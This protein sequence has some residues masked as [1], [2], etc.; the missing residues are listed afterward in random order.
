MRSGPVATPW[1]REFWL[2]AALD[3]STGGGRGSRKT[4]VAKCYRKGP[5]IMRLSNFFLLSSCLLAMSCGSSP[6]VT[7]PPPD[8]ST[9]GSETGTAEAGPGTDVRINPDVAAPLDAP[10]GADARTDTG[11]PA[12]DVRTTDVRADVVA[13]IDSP[14]A[15]TDVRVTTD[16]TTADA[17][18]R[19][20]PNPCMNG[21][22]CASNSSGFVCTC[23]P[24]YSGPNCGTNIDD[25]LPNQCMNGGTCEDRVNSFACTCAAGFSG[26]NCATNIN[27]CSP[28]PCENGGTCTDGVNG[29]TCACLPGFMGNRCQGNTD[30][31]S[32]SPCENGG[33]CSDGV[34]GFTCACPPG[35]SGATC[36]TNVDDCSPNPCSNGGTCADGVNGFTCSCAPGFSGTT[37]ETNAD[38]CA[39]APCQNGGTCVDGANAYSCTCPAGYSGTNCETN[40][41]ECSGAPC[42][43]GGTCVDGVNAFTCTCLPGFTGA[44]CDNNPDDCVT[45]PCQNG[46]TCTD[47]T[48]T[49]TCTCA[50]GYAGTN[51]ETNIDDCTPTS[52]A[53]GGTC[54]D[55][56]NTFTC[57]CRRGFVGDTCETNIDDCRNGPCQNGGTCTD[58]DDTFTC[59][60]APGFQGSVCS[61]NID[62]CTPNQC[63]NG[64][65]CVDGVNGFSCTC[66]PG[67]SGP[68]C[69][70]NI[71]ECIPNLCQ[72]GATCNDGINSFTCSCAAGYTGLLCQTNIDDCAPNPCLNGGSCSDGVNT[73]T[74]ACAGGYTGPTCATA[75]VRQSCL[76]ILNAGESTGNG[77]YTIDPD[78]TG[79]VAP[80]TAFC[81]MTT[82]GGGYT[83]VTV[84]GGTSTNS[85]LSANS[86]QALGLEMFVPRTQ[87]Q[88]AFLEGRY[89]QDFF[90]T[91]SGI[92]G[93]TPANYTT[94]VMN[95]ASASAC[96]ANWFAIDGGSWWLRNAAY[97]EPNGDYTANLW[98]GT[99]NQ[100]PS[101]RFNDLTGGYFTGGSYICSTNDKDPVSPCSPGPRAV[102]AYQINIPADANWPTE[103]NA[104]YAVDNRARHAAMTYSRVGYCL[105]LG[106]NYAYV[107]MNDFTGAVKSRLSPPSDWIYDQAVT[108]LT[109]RSNVAGV[110]NVINASTGSM[111]FWPNCYST[112]PSPIYDNDDTIDSN[113]CYGSM[114]IH[115]GTSTVIAWNRFAQGG[116]ND[117]VGIGN[118]S[119]NVHTD[120][121]FMANAGTGSP[122]LRAYM[123]P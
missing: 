34:N 70:V 5:K 1:A 7:I 94:C 45:A 48:N 2:K 12:T 87:A 51:C 40:I 93:T 24:G 4:S 78:G 6:T 103:A 18:N 115:N 90:E 76:Q 15:A 82:D 42:Q 81:D 22:T 57:S 92:Y 105:S 100:Y 95:S 36:S 67:Y 110:S 39:S 101:G 89:N 83:Y 50:S 119:G 31:C 97:S 35:Y 63:V 59:T 86:C 72:N 26:T 99:D 19:C 55:G 28:N 102:L 117:D 73:F 122:T 43:N 13:P 77:D 52:C 123:I 64:S 60:C 112:P 66:A 98:L 111:E 106:S 27:D 116:A 69:E 96:S 121:T 61:V 21:G 68:L 14:P 58:G 62:E 85:R 41:D 10:A 114:Q 11:A 20:A 16:V 120:W 33:T 88:Y 29:F 91:V 8:G 37:C 17:G 118:N 80:M 56:L 75:P 74:C 113:D 44:L 109:V 104:V 54:V 65:T 71:N 47:G 3:T 25:C 79:P 53:N 107:E 46:G 84:T 108:N 32:T 23:A 49:Y 38:D 30:D 9:G